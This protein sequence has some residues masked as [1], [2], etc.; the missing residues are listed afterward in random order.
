MCVTH[1]CLWT[2]V[3]LVLSRQAFVRPFSILI[4]VLELSSDLGLGKWW[5]LISEDG[6]LAERRED[7]LYRGEK[8]AQCDVIF[9]TPPVSWSERVTT[10]RLNEVVQKILDMKPQWSVA[11]LLLLL[12]AALLLLL[13]QAST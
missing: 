4:E 5:Y 8:V 1:P 13:F 12:L 10:K 6:H 3:C 11:T 7:P 2:H 9:L